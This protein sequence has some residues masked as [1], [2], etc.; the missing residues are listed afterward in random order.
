[1]YLI[2]KHILDDALSS[3]FGTQLNGSKYCYVSLTI[4]LNMN[5]LLTHINNQAVLFQE[6]HFC[7]SHFFARGWNVK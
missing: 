6:I 4:H 5:H 7:I 1:M 3:F 2:C